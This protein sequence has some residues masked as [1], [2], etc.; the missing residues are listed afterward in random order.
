MNYELAVPSSQNFLRD[1]MKK[2]V[3]LNG[4]KPRHKT[5]I[6]LPLMYETLSHKAEI[7]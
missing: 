5:F 7:C 2:N 6:L 4:L 3:C 1:S